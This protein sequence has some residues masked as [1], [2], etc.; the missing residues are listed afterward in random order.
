M[1]ILRPGLI[2]IALAA[3]A[4][5][6][7]QL[8]VDVPDTNSPPE[9]NHS[10]VVN[11]AN[12]VGQTFTVTRNGLDRIDVVLAVEK[13]V[14][15]AGITFNVEEVPF[16]Q[17]RQVDERL[18]SLPVGNVSDYPPGT[19]LQ[20]WYSFQFD[21]VSDSGGKQFFF[22]LEGKSVQGPNSASLLM[23]F[24]N[25]YPL[26]QAYINGAPT[27]A[28]VVFRAYTRGRLL[29]YAEIVAG[30]VMKDQP[31]LAGSPA[32]LAG[33]AAAYIVISAGVVLAVKR[34]S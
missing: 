3:L 30:N 18:T 24:H 20:K 1:R 9:G 5:G 28:H 8:P 22:S 32:L 16:K 26:G 4:I 19:I 34:S 14:P 23:F 17:A 15:D 10:G 29:D 13:P 6:L 12:A 11:G 21:P 2:L 33:L 7:L 31:A 25:E 27:D